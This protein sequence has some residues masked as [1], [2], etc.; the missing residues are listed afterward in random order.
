M[1]F[2][3]AA[4][5][6]FRK[7]CNAVR[8]PFDLFKLGALMHR[9]MDPDE[10][11]NLSPAPQVKFLP[12]HVHKVIAASDKAFATYCP[13]FYRGKITFFKAETAI[14]VPF[15]ANSLWGKMC[16]KIAVYSIPG[17]HRNLIT[18]NVKLLAEILEACIIFEFDQINQAR[19]LKE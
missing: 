3:E 14:R 1:P 6:V 7:A 10:I 15:D 2:Y 19:S 13:R 9:F 17:T 11:E 12:Q 8:T 18:H 4:P 16:S 5:F